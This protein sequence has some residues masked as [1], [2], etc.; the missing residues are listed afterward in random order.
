MPRGPKGEK[1]PADVIGSAVHVMQ[2]PR[3]SS[4]QP[5]ETIYP[6]PGSDAE[7]PPCGWTSVE[8]AVSYPCAS[9]HLQ[10]YC[11]GG[12]HNVGK[13]LGHC[14]QCYIRRRRGRLP[15]PA[16]A[17]ELAVGIIVLDRVDFE[18]P[19]GVKQS[20]DTWATPPWSNRHRLA[21]DARRGTIM[22][23]EQSCGDQAS[24]QL[25]KS[26]VAGQLA[27]SAQSPHPRRTSSDRRRITTAP[28]RDIQSLL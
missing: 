28:L 15:R 21:T 13:D 7:I 4:L 19:P 25:L 6:S 22:H 8:R 16:L 26:I 17:V 23:Y 3:V 18:L 24:T 5:P 12:G 10:V 14:D 9:F 11:E 20:S 2:M 27:R 1:R